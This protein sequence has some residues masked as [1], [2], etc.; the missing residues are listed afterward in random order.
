MPR[1]KSTTPA[2]VFVPVVVIDTREQDP[3]AFEG[4]DRD[5]S[6]GGGPMTVVT[7]R[8]TLKSGDYSLVGFEDQIACERKS[9]QDCYGTIGQG[10]DRFERELARL[11]EMPWSAV[12]VEDSLQH[13]IESPP[14]HSHLDPKTVFRS[15]IAWQQRFPRVHWMFCD[16]RRL[17]EA[18]TLRALERF[19]RERERESRERVGREKV[20]QQVPVIES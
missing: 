2:G 6:E 10:R 14:V 18:Y 9:R 16:S 3:F 20:Q 4:F 12:V 1:V 17:A 15:V 19:W 7:V 13:L 5:A 11:N 8:G